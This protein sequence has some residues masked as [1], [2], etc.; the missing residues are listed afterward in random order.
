MTASINYKDSIAITADEAKNIDLS[1]ADHKEAILGT[2][3][4][5]ADCL[6]EGSTGKEAQQLL[7]QFKSAL[8]TAIIGNQATPT[9]FIPTPTSLIPGVPTP[10]SFDPN[11]CKPRRDAH[12][13]AQKR[14]QRKALCLD[15][16]LHIERAL[17]NAWHNA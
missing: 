3:S 12:S 15:S 10:T 17:H 2:F 11:A 6:N 7:S 13:S 1:A 9:S 5:M 4:A 14:D 16:H 8:I